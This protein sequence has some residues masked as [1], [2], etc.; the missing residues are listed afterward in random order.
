MAWTR[1]GMAHRAN[2]TVPGKGPKGMGGAIYLVAGVRRVIV[3]MEH[4]SK[5]GSPKLLQECSLPITGKGVV[6]RVITNLC[7]IDLVAQGFEVVEPAPGVTP[8]LV[9]NS[10][11]AG[12]TFRLPH[13]AQGR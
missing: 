13:M 10:T 11:G 9:S 6:Q 12:I 7:V 4:T 5:D 1:Q 3:L 8:E 2:W